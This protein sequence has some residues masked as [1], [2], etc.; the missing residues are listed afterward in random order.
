MFILGYIEGLA[1][2]QEIFKNKG[3]YNIYLCMDYQMYDHNILNA[4][5]YNNL[6]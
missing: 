2:S 4:T 6:C 3:K 1:C 5:L